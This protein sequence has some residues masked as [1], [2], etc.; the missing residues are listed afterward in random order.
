MDEVDMNEVEKML[1]WAMHY[2]IAEGNGVYKIYAVVKSP[3]FDIRWLS[4]QADGGP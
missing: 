2:H 3:S 1:R 4:T